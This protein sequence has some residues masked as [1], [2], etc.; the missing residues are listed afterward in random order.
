MGVE[1][2]CSEERAATHPPVHRRLTPF[3]LRLLLL[4]VIFVGVG[5]WAAHIVVAHA[6]SQGKPEYAVRLAAYMTGLFLGGS[7]ATVVGVVMLLSGRR[8]SAPVQEQP[9]NEA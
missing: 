7:A 4:L 9:D 8:V 1:D 6:V 3:L 2:R 5:L